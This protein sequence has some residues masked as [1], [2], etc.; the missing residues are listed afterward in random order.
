M[1]TQMEGCRP[2][3]P[4]SGLWPA[5]Q[6][7]L[8]SAG[9]CPLWVLPKHQPT[10]ATRF[11]DTSRHCH[12]CGPCTFRAR[13]SSVPTSGKGLRS[14]QLTHACQNPPHLLSQEESPGPLPSALPD[15]T[16]SPGQHGS[17]SVLGILSSC[18]PHQFHFLVLQSH[19][20]SLLICKKTS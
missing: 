17:R 19:L 13:R 14:I 8:P 3:R 16:S 7:P 6:T 2:G 4:P 5:T 9:P 10:S 20:T 1:E 12:Q 18:G 11:W 15:L